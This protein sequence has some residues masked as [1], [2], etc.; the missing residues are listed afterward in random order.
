MFHF[1]KGEEE[2]EDGDKEDGEED[3]DDD[4]VVVV[5]DSLAAFIAWQAF[6]NASSC[7]ARCTPFTA[8]AVYRILEEP[9]QDPDGV[10]RLAEAVSQ[11]ADQGDA[12]FWNTAIVSGRP[13]SLAK[14]CDD[15]VQC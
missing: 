12:E 3:K 8:T 6:R 14:L 1:Q 7:F 15:H 9:G 10:Q 11:A 4:T 2:E 5:Q 13:V